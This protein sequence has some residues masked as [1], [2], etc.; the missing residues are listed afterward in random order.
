MKQ[1]KHALLVLGV[2]CLLFAGAYLAHRHGDYA[3]MYS[4]LKEGARGWKNSPHR[5]D[6]ELGVSLVPGMQG[7]ETFAKGPDVPSRISS[8]GFRI[9]LHMP[10]TVPHNRPLVLSLGCS[11]T[12]G[13]SCMAKDTFAFKVGC[14]LGGSSINAAVGS[15]GLVHMLLIGRRVIPEYRPDYV[16]AQ[17][18]PWLVDRSVKGYLPTFHGKMPSPYFYEPKKGKLA[19]HPPYY[20]TGILSYD[21]EHYKTTE[22]SLADRLSFYWNVAIPMLAYDDYHEVLTAVGRITGRFPRPTSDRQLVLESVYAELDR[23]CR[24]NGGTMLIVALDNTDFDESVSK[25]EKLFLQERYGERFIDTTPVLRAEVPDRQG[26]E[27]SRKVYAH[28]REGVLVDWHPNEKA[29]DLYTRAIVKRMESL[30]K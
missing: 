16:L 14:A 27:A 12:Y 18:S 3:D 29:H 21:T 1:L 28:Y 26:G 13:S 11:F 19:I 5:V 23:L 8:L 17:Y 24:N 6:P 20:P 2:T 4:L 22:R 25:E 15:H 7:A 9:P 10:D 30:R